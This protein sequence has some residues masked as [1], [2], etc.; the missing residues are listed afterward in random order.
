[1]KTWSI[2]TT[3]RNPE[4]LRNFLKILK[5]IEG[6]EFNEENQILYQILLIQNKEYK[7]NNIPPKY[8]SYYDNLELE[9]PYEIAE[10]IFNFQNYK[11][12]SQRGRQ[13]ANHS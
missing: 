12:P 8:K 6:K 11:D 7:P 13:S 2:S 9:I 10:D 4:R 3:V 1:M 5:E